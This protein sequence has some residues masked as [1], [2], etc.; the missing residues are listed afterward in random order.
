MLH[1]GYAM[2]RVVMRKSIPNDESVAL[3]SVAT[4]ELKITRNDE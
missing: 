3:L 1:G 4:G 2:T